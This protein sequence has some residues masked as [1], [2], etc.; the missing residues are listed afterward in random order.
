MG[1]ILKRI[2]FILVWIFEF[3]KFCF[4]FDDASFKFLIPLFMNF[5]TFVYDSFLS[6]ISLLDMMKSTKLR[7]LNNKV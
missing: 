2:C 5:F 7:Q 6:P 1:L 3:Y 4:K